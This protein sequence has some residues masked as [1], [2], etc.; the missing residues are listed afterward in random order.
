MIK[1]IRLFVLLLFVTTIL[2][3][4]SD[5]TGDDPSV[6]SEIG[7]PPAQVDDDENLG[8]L[9]DDSGANGN[10]TNFETFDVITIIGGEDI[11]SGDVDGDISE[12]K[13]NSPHGMV[14]IGNR[15]YIA[16]GDNRKIRVLELDENGGGTLSTL[17]GGHGFSDTSDGEAKFGHFYQMAVYDGDIFI[18]D[19]QNTAI[20]KVE[21]D[22]DGSLLEVTTIAGAKP[23]TAGFKDAYGT[24][25]RFFLPHGIAAGDDELFVADT[26]NHVIRRI[27]FSDTEVTTVAGSPQVEGFSDSEDGEVLFHRPTS[28]AID[29]NYLYITDTFNNRIRRMN[30]ATYEVDTLVGS[31]DAMTVDG[32][33]QNASL[34][35][36]RAIHY[37][38]GYLFVT[39]GVTIPGIP[40]R[41]GGEVLRRV[42]VLTGEIKTIAGTV[43]MKQTS[44]GDLL[45]ASFNNPTGVL[46]L[47]ER[48]VLVADTDSHSLRLVNYQVT[49]VS[50][51]C[52]DE[53]I[54]DG[55]IQ[56]AVQVEL[57]DSTNAQGDHFLLP[58]V[59]LSIEGID[60]NTVH[61]DAIRVEVDGDELLDYSLS[62]NKY[63]EHVDLILRNGTDGKKAWRSDSLYSIKICHQIKTEGGLPVEP[64]QVFV[65]MRHPNEQED[66]GISHSN[67]TRSGKF[68]LPVNYDPDVEY[69]MV[70]LLHGLNGNGAGMI[71][72]LKNYADAMGVILFGPDGFLRE[73]PFGNGNIY[74]FNPNH[75][76]QPPEDYTFA[77]DGLDRMLAAFAVD[78]DYLMVAGLSMGAPA[79]LFFAGDVGV[80]SHAA[81]LHGVR[82]NY[83]PNAENDIANLLWFPWE[84]TPLGTHRPL[85]WYSTSTDDWVT[86]YDKVPI[87]GMSVD[88][89]L[90]YVEG[91]G[92]D[93][94]HKF[95][96]PGGHYMT[97]QEKQDLFDW[98]LFGLEP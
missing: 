32:V 1:I 21:L 77:M 34:D 78:Q 68:Y 98:F 36:P 22:G 71:N 82:W 37:Y 11:G 85:F 57:D 43:G 40:K 87:P 18:A 24:D 56:E 72:I 29:E 39:E 41:I 31:G 83:D 12:A 74:Y 7:D 65:Q 51:Y 8:N 46:Y 16:D 92:Y 50:G 19:T 94:T 70:L 25:A 4:S 61:K 89:D 64:Q 42:N 75:S 20:R 69:P 55:E 53:P 73:D 97:E 14:L 60:S 15:I 66:I 13:L 84:Q 6:F 47:P 48:G 79:T 3:C 62:V 76:N 52:G 95:D 26:Y 10:S 49:D 28:L 86:N 91:G 93:V 23:A 59:V 17:A 5:S 9:A 63:K 27:D 58:A 35:S 54:F 67:G 90:A 96:Y 45:E 2:G 44:D 81:M 88:D 38:G 80:F 33:G 30:L